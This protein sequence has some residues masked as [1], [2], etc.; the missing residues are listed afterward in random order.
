M[1]MFT[2]PYIQRLMLQV[3]T[4]AAEHDS[5]A[6][7]NDMTLPWVRLLELRPRK[8]RDLSM[9]DPSGPPRPL[10]F[11]AR[12]FAVMPSGNHL[13]HTHR[14]DRPGFLVEVP[15]EVMG[16]LQLLLLLRS[17]YRCSRPLSITHR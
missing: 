7:C 1:T 10:G 11:A 6:T 9:L 4:L 14:I 16:G 15:E 8:S 13:V 3:S 12:N 2:V 17:W 5:K